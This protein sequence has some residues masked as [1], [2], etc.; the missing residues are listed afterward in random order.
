MQNK[1]MNIIISGG[2]IVDGTG[3]RPY[4]GSIRICADRIVSILPPGTTGK[5][6]LVIDARGLIIAPGFI[7]NHS[8]GDIT[9][10]SGS[11]AA[12]KLEQGITTEITGNCGITVSPGAAGAMYKADLSGLNFAAR[13]IGRRRLRKFSGFMQLI[14]KRDL[15]VNTAFFVGH[16]AIRGAVMGFSSGR[17]GAK[18]MAAMKRLLADAMESGA[19]GLSTGLEYPPGSFAGSEELTELATVV[20]EYGGVYS[21]HMRGQGKTLESSVR[22]AIT[23]AEV[24]GVRLLISHLKARGKDN[25]GSVGRALELIEEARSGG[26]EVITDLYH[27]DA[28]A[29][30]LIGTV[31]NQFAAGGLKVL[32]E[33]LKEPSFRKKVKTAMEETYK[34]A[35]GLFQNAGYE[36]IMVSKAPVTKE[37]VGKTITELAAER[38]Q[39]PFDVFADVISENDGA[40]EGVYFVTDYNDIELITKHPLSV[41]CTDAGHPPAL[42]PRYTGEFVKL[43]SEYV[44][45]RK[46]L[47]LQEAVRKASAG[48]AG[49]FGFSSKGI[50]KEGYDADI[51]VFDLDS[52]QAFAD[53]KTPDAKNRGIRW[54]LVNGEAAVRDD[55]FTGVMNG[56]VLKRRPAQ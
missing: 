52:L 35:D 56:R 24:S 9:I 31:P 19:L 4:P 30:P 44:R 28:A 7:D 13:C 22:E 5:A 20:R 33:K 2:T 27:Y 11:A 23:L 32:A 47:S 54:V 55:N 37:E 34:D 17:P 40:A 3:A 48:P 38:R 14:E 21:T 25:W 1:Y 29:C 50:I 26:T 51:V 18:E 45:D 10:L 46:V 43:I 15:A 42:H 39:E 16:G 53:Y 12:N 49:F 6:E 8:H 41:F 36:N